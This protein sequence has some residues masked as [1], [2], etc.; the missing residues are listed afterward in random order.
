MSS[1]RISFMEPRNF[2]PGAAVFET[3]K[4]VIPGT[5]SGKSAGLLP[6]IGQD[7]NRSGHRLKPP[8]DSLPAAPVNRNS[9]PRFG[10]A[11]RHFRFGYKFVAK[12]TC[13][14]NR[15]R[16]PADAAL[17]AV[18]RPLSVPRSNPGSSESS[19]ISTER[20][21]SDARRPAFPRNQER[22]VNTPSELPAKQSVSRSTSGMGAIVTACLVARVEP[23]GLPDSCLSA[24]DQIPGGMTY[25]SH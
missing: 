7:R 14:A 24:P 2:E 16:G 17:G 11:D 15:I 5:P 12:W 4:K 10:A 25:G 21:A 8:I 9:K 18:D 13:I 23:L 20:S 19:S 1:S 6:G 22:R 3:G